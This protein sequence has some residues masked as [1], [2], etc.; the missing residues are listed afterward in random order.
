MKNL[1]YLLLFFIL[2]FSSPTSYSQSN[3]ATLDVVKLLKDSKA[4][5]SMKDQLNAVAKKI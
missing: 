5:I 4:A 3:I 2:I 1:K